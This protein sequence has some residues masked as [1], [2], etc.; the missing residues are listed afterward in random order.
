MDDGR[1]TLRL[2]PKSPRLSLEVV[3]QSLAAFGAI[4]SNLQ[5]EQDPGEKTVWLVD[6]LKLDSVTATVIPSS[7]RGVETARLA[8]DGLGCLEEPGIVPEFFPDAC[9][10]AILRL[11]DL[12]ARS[13]TKVSVAGL[14]RQVLLTQRL[15][16]PVREALN[17]GS[18]EAWGSVEGRL[19]MVTVHDKLAC[20]IYA[21]VSG[22]RV[23]CTFRPDQQQRVI[24]AFDRRIIATGLVRYDARGKTISIRLEAIEV[25]PPDERL[26]SVEKMAG[27]A[28]D[29][30]GGLPSPEYVRGLRDEQH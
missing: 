19:E 30:T 28:P 29:I 3:A 10:R 25:F 21:D 12:T 7:A 22:E 6:D 15:T 5:Q 18:W 23:V 16:E 8:M 17:R 9:I 24:E 11:Y 1:L 27:M 20:S 26:P 14:G 13:D 2:E 4:L